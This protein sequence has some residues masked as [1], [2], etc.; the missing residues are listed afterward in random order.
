MPSRLSRAWRRPT[1]EQIEDDELQRS[2]DQAGCRLLASQSD[3][4]VCSL[5]GELRS[6]TTRPVSDGVSALEAQLYDGSGQ[7]TLVWLGRREIKG[8]EPGRRLTVHGRIG[9]RG[10]SC[11][12]YNP[13]YELDA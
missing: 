2:A 5:H 11:V 8:I 7:V 1:L 12:L 13:R 10:D 6:V 3:R 9:R 4:A